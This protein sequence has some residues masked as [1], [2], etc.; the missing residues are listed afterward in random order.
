MGRRI[1]ILGAGKLGEAMLSGFLS[2][3]WRSPDELVATSRRPERRQ[4]LADRFGVETT[5]D[6]AAAANGAA[7]VVLSV[8]PQDME[9]VLAE[10]SPRSHRF[11][12]TSRPSCRSPPV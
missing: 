12:A 10:I 3:G 9:V 11:S 8:K 7:L 1:A 4:E 5:A 2:S 6:N